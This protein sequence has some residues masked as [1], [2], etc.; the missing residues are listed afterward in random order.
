[1]EQ[2]VRERERFMAQFY[3]KDRNEWTPLRFGAVKDNTGI[4]LFVGDGYQIRL[5]PSEVQQLVEAIE[6]EPEDASAFGM[7][8]WPDD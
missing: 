2:W 6:G 5:E 1:M 8:G 3:N 7:P 4:R